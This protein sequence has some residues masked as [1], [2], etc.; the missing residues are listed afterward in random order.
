MSKKEEAEAK[1]E[2]RG[3]ASGEGTSGPAPIPTLERRRPDAQGQCSGASSRTLSLGG[4]CMW[5]L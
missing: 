3:R 1:A 2:G 4:A 5:L